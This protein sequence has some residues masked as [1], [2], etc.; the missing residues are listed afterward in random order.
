MTD[1]SESY[2]FPHLAD[3][4]GELNRFGA[5]I[6]GS[7]YFVI[8]A[9]VIIFVVHKIARKFLC[10]SL[11]NK[12]FALVLIFTLYALVLVAAALL[13]L[14]RL[15]FD[16]TIVG[17]VALLAVI[18]VAALIFAIAPYLP[19]LPFKLGNMV[20]VADVMGN[21]EA[22]TPVFTRI[23]TFDGRT[24]FIPT[25]T[26]WAKNIVN[27]HYTPARRV[28]L[29]LKVSP[30][31]S[32]ADA[33]AV[34]TEIMHGDDRVLEDPAPLARI[35]STSAE[36]VDMVGLCWVPNADFLSARSDLYEKV[37]EATQ[38]NAGLSLALDRQQVVLSGEVSRP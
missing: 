24:V 18:V 2:A 33:R 19:T 12:R 5:V 38:T 3:T 20:E 7:L 27:Y 29:D 10:P 6:V 14:S 25:P 28:E 4:L 31:H 1:L 13:V 9:L 16:V 36:G 17:R 8:V 32:V 35:N 26:I 30:D 21:I 11:A 23:Q 34:L 15:G 22:I 37:V